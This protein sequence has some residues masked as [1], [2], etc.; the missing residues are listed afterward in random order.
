MIERIVK[1]KGTPGFGVRTVNIAAALTYKERFSFLE[2]DVWDPSPS[3][4]RWFF[5]EKMKLSYRRI[6]GKLSSIEIPAKSMQLWSALIDT[7]AIDI[8]DGVHP[9]LDVM[10]LVLISSQSANTRGS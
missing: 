7:L 2:D 4:C 10:N 1:F 8:A 9:S 3:W 6:T 5:A